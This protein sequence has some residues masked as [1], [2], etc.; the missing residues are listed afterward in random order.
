M[1]CVK[2]SNSRA[3]RDALA[4]HRFCRARMYDQGWLV[5]KM[6]CMT[7]SQKAQPHVDPQTMKISISD[8]D[9]YYNIQPASCR[10]YG[11]PAM[12]GGAPAAGM[13]PYGARPAGAPVPYG[14]PVAPAPYGVPPA[15][16][17]NPVAGHNPFSALQ[18]PP[19]PRY[20]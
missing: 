9:V 15:A 18:R 16:A 20:Y 12:G 2:G 8:T 1:L 13:A 7:A 5:F 4:G 14:A 6:P 17:A 3:F 19:P 11:G 10:P